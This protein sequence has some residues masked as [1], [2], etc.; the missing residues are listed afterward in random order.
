MIRSICALALFLI[1]SCS[2]AAI[3]ESLGAKLGGLQPPPVQEAVN[4]FR[5]AVDGSVKRET[6]IVL[7][8]VQ[9]IEIPKDETDTEATQLLGDGTLYRL[10]LDRLGKRGAALVRFDGVGRS[11]PVETRIPL[12]PPAGEEL[13]NESGLGLGLRIATGSPG[14]RIDRNRHGTAWWEEDGPKGRLIEFRIDGDRATMVP[15]GSS[16]DDPNKPI[17]RRFNDTPSREVPYRFVT[18]AVRNI[19]RDTPRA[20]LGGDGFDLG[21]SRIG[22]QRT[23]AVVESPAYDLPSVDVAEWEPGELT[24]TIGY[25]TENQKGH[26]TQVTYDANAQSWKEHRPLVI[27]PEAQ[28]VEVADVAPDSALVNLILPW[29]GTGDDPETGLYWIR[30]GKPARHLLERIR[31]MKTVTV[32]DGFV[33]MFQDEFKDNI[34]PED[35]RDIYVLRAQGERLALFKFTNPGPCSSHEF[36]W[37]GDNRFAATFCGHQVI[38]FELPDQ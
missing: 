38:L 34:R 14:I 3:K 23:E 31:E 33:A 4:V 35:Q 22:N 17:E 27:F 20:Y 28:G 12:V 26:A 32:D 16:L 1:T 2:P 18:G 30:R 36:A 24:V 15:P 6:A 13:R 10:E 37:L 21:V 25:I 5:L 19:A 7:S 9:L 29:N 8:N 11:A